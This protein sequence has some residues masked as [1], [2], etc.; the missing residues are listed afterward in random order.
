MSKA[1]ALGVN[2]HVGG[3]PPAESLDDLLARMHEKGG[4]PTPFAPPTPLA[5]SGASEAS[6]AAESVDDVIARMHSSMSDMEAGPGKHASTGAILAALDQ[7]EQRITENRVS[8]L[9]ALQVERDHLE[10]LKEALANRAAVNAVSPRQPKALRSPSIRVRAF[11]GAGTFRAASTVLVVRSLADLLERAT[12]KLGMMKPAGRCFS[13]EE[14]LLSFD[15]M[16]LQRREGGGGGGV[17]HVAVTDG[18]TNL[19]VEAAKQ[20]QAA[21]VSAAEA[22]KKTTRLQHAHQN[23]NYI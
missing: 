10:T 12:S 15:Q 16:L 17:L 22:A 11:Y 2:I 23:I 1:P 18:S 20:L 21:A 13:D 7:L 6:P 14:E 4:P 8:S 5:P 19:P 9:A 3:S